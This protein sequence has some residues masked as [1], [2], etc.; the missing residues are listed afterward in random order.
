MCLE[1][2]S[3]NQ[4]EDYYVFKNWI[5]QAWHG[6]GVLGYGAGVIGAPAIA[7]APAAIHAAPAVAVAP[8]A[9]H[10]APAVAVAP[11]AVATRYS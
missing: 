11:A 9:I 1:K 6:A 10:A 2:E 8:A 5:F 4:R 7:A 3:S